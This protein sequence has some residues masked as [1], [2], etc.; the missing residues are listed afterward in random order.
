[1]RSLQACI[2]TDRQLV[3]EREGQE[4]E[5]IR[6]EDPAVSVYT[7]DDDQF[8]PQRSERPDGVVVGA[9]ADGAWWVCFV[10]LKHHAEPEGFARF[11]RQVE[12][13][14]ELS[15]SEHLDDVLR[16]LRWNVD[17]L[18]CLNRGQTESFDEE[19]QCLMASRDQHCA[20]LAELAER[21][22]G[23]RDDV[24]DALARVDLDSARVKALGAHTKGLILRARLQLL[25]G[26]WHFMPHGTCQGSQ[27]AGARHGDRHH[28]RWAQG[29]DLSREMAASSQAGDHAVA[30]IVVLMQRSVSRPPSMLRR[31][32]ALP[33][34]PSSI[35]FGEEALCAG[36]PVVLRVLP[37]QL[38]ARNG[39]FV[40]IF[41][42]LDTLLRE[43]GL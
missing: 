21:I 18:R 12:N 8:W 4:A 27:N 41:A 16:R 32:G 29:Q 7:L 13:L 24:T 40:R 43:C 10:E 20:R 2:S 26:V 34:S 14:L 36:K 1:V 6:F 30:A 15:L 17:E 11:S 38:Q 42:D 5:G 28:Q 23:L 37:T 25:A 9:R 19:S 39:R 22:E 3:E 35:Q 31:D 33:S